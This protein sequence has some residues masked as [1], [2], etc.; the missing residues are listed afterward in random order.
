MQRKRNDR[1]AAW[2]HNQH[3]AYLLRLDGP[4]LAWE[5]LRRN[6]NYQRDW[7]ARDSANDNNVVAGRWGLAALFDPALDAR[8][9]SVRW[10]GAGAGPSSSSAQRPTVLTHLRAIQALDGIAAGASHRAIAVVLFGRWRVSREWHPD[11]R[12]RAEVRRLID[13]ARAYSIGE[14]RALVGSIGLNRARPSP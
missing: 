5:Y 6:V 3:Y 12:L 13:R 7:T 14:Y 1:S 10:Q 11:S 8:I 4:A 2:R 9:G